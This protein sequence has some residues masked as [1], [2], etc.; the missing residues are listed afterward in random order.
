MVEVNWTR[1]ADWQLQNFYQY[2]EQYN[3]DYCTKFTSILIE[4]LDLLKDFPQMGRLV[5]EDKEQVLRE[6]FVEKF[7]L[8]YFY[9]G[10]NIT[11]YNL[12]HFKQDFNFES[13]M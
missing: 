3:T 4:K 12:L 2:M 7:R 6:I 9:D 1:H 5:P 10:V 8:F 11:V 13:E